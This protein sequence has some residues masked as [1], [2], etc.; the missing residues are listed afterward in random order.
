MT[1]SGLESGGVGG[2]VLGDDEAVLH[3]DDPR[4]VAGDAEVVGHENH[5]GAVLLLETAEEFGD[6]GGV[7]AVEVAG[8]LVG[9]EDG[10]IVDEAAGDRRALAFTSGE[11]RRQVPATV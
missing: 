9:E 5:G 1:G 11:L 4:R 2:I 6:L 8:G 7:L 10:G 3:P